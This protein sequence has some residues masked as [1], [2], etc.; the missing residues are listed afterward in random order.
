M[1]TAK[2]PWPTLEQVLRRQRLMRRMMRTTGVDVQ[3]DAARDGLA[4]LDARAKCRYCRHE[5]ACEVW[6][7]ATDGA[8]S[9]PD[10]CPNARFFAACRSRDRETPMVEPA[11]QPT[12]AIVR[13]PRPVVR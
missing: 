4:F 11:I 13:V 6:L 10:F 7:N 12:V 5:G 2:G 3:A 1:M 8:R 9:A